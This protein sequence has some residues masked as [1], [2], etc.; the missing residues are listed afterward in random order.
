MLSCYQGNLRSYIFQNSLT[1]N[2]D[3]GPKGRFNAPGWAGT[4]PLG[5][6]QS[7]LRVLD[8]RLWHTGGGGGAV[9]PRFT[10]PPRDP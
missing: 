1:C 10:P 5:L 6:S 4:P 9:G 3:Q 2:L 8:G 7:S